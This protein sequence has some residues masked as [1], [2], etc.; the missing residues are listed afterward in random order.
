M[1]HL[2]YIAMAYAVA[3]L[4]LLSIVTGTLLR[5]RGLLKEL[6]SLETLGVRPDES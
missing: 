6:K 3:I 4:G 2:G 1:S 5:K